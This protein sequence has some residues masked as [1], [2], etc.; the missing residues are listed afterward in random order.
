REHG[1]QALQLALREPALDLG[2]VEPIMLGLAL[3][4]Y[5]PVA[6]MAGRNARLEQRA[7]TGKAGT[8]ADQQQWT[9]VGGRVE[10]RVRTQAQVYRVARLRQLG[11]PAAARAQSALC[12]A[13]LPHQQMERSVRRHRC[14][15]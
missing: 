14:D 11:E 5:Q 15:G 13:H 1:I 12:V 9:A 3:A 4:E 2:A 7:Q 6:V 10:V 8:V